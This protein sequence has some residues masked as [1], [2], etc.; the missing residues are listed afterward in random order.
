MF[1]CF[2]I[3]KQ[4]NREKEAGNLHQINFHLRGLLYLGDKQL[5]L[6]YYTKS[7]LSKKLL[8][9]RLARKQEKIVFMK[10]I[11]IRNVQMFQAK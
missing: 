9:Q 5:V 8:N 6:H 10:R 2:I 4:V 3:Y 1:I 11:V 7:S